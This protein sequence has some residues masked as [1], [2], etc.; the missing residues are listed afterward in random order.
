ML[1]ATLYC[2]E[3]LTKIVEKMI[4][5]GVVLIDPVNYRDWWCLLDRRLFP[6]YSSLRDPG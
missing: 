3:Y 4:N 2:A 6:R 5:Y 1:C